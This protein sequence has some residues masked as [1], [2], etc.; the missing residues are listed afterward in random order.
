[1]NKLYQKFHKEYSFQSGL[2]VINY[3]LA[4]HIQHAVISKQITLYAARTQCSSKTVLIVQYQYLLLYSTKS[5]KKS[6]TQ[7]CSPSKEPTIKDR[8][9]NIGRRVGHNKI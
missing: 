8:T 1:M 9:V 2:A 3:L 4:F 7:K 5:M 6:H